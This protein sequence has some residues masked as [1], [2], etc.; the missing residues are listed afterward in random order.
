MEIALHVALFVVASVL[1]SLGNTLGYHRLLT[2]RA[3]KTHPL[4]R[5][6]LTLLSATH[7]GSPIVWVGLHR[8]HHAFSDEEGDPHSTNDGF[9]FAHSGWL[10]H[11]KNKWCSILL[12]LS[13]FA[14]QVR[15]LLNDIQRLRGQLKPDWQ[16]MCRRDLMKE[17][18]MRFLDTPL[19]I[20]SLF[21]L[22]VVAAWLIA[23]WW[24]LLWLW[25]M[26]VVQNNTSWVI[27]SICHWHGF[28]VSD[29]K[30]KDQSRDVAALGWITNGDSYHNS[31]H[32]YPA[33]AKHAIHGGADLS[34]W[35]VCGLARLGLA[36]DIKLPKGYAY[37]EWMVH[38]RHYQLPPIP[39]VAASPAPADHAA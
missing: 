16:K 17:P 35:V 3:F 19:V 26:H 38:G 4:I 15:Y 23:G 31:H 25:A 22:Q 36:S 28:G 10:F 13:G 37:P 34:W 5:N 18:F 6:T 2:H 30:S 14:L 11:T 8:V 39:P 24:G 29:A 21:A 9:W 12:A 27:N 32:L 33:S 1:L 20:P 7:S